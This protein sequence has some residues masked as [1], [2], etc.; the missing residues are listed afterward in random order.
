M[1]KSSEKNNK[2]LRIMI[3]LI[4]IIIIGLTGYII[5][6]K[7]LS[8]DTKEENNNT[9]INNK[10][11]LTEEDAK[12]IVEEKTKL[13]FIYENSLMPYC[14]ERDDNDYIKTGEF[15]RW[16][17]S[18]SY[19]SK[20]ELLNYLRTF[21]SDDVIKEYSVE[22]MY[23]LPIYKEENNKLYCYHPNIGGGNNYNAGKTY[24]Q[25]LNVTENYIDAIGN[26]YFT[27]YGEMMSN[28]TIIRLEKNK[29][30]NWIMTS[31]AP[32]KAGIQDLF[33]V[34]WILENII[35]ANITSLEH[36][37]IVNYDER[38]ISDSQEIEKLKKEINLKYGHEDEVK[39]NIFIEYDEVGYIKKIF[40]HPLSN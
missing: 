25:I 28:I 13:V 8:K 39:F 6:E 37:I 24:Y 14:G 17:A 40:I 10:V 34:E 3:F 19:S 2:F 9:N 5:Y 16:D 4:S 33:S 20:N 29:K 30:S 36:K 21:M 1:E 31:Y 23:T 27:N 11:K 38:E 35:F 26:I 12:K 18:T 15:Q 7:A 32:I 22:K